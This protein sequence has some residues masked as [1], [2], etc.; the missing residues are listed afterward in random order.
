MKQTLHYHSCFAHP[1]VY[2]LNS[3]STHS[4]ENVKQSMPLTTIPMHFFSFSAMKNTTTV[5]GQ[6]F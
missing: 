5:E 6:N 4:H 3:H 1:Y 2:R